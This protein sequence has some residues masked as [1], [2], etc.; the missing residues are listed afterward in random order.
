M[1]MIIFSYSS[2]S[3]Y[4][5]QHDLLLGYKVCT[6]RGKYALGYEPV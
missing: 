3:E 5:L 1:C 6:Y 4:S 2:M